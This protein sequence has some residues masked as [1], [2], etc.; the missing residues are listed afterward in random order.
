MVGMTGGLIFKVSVVCSASY[1]NCPWY[2]VLYMQS[3]LIIFSDL[4]ANW[5]SFVQE[6]YMNSLSGRGLT[7]YLF[8]KLVPSILDHPMIKPSV[9][10]RALLL[11]GVLG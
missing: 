5:A 4:Y 2:L 11:C 8:G 10:T 6:D 7:V 1:T 9:R 3:L